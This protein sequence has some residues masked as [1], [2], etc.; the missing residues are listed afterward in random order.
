[1]EQEFL[2]I[3]T[4]FCVLIQMNNVHGGD[5]NTVITVVCGFDHSMVSIYSLVAFSFFRVSNIRST[6]LKHLL[7]DISLQ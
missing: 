6:S 3:A 7:L 4:G 2:P 5:G 1:M